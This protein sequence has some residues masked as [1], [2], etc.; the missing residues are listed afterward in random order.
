VWVKKPPLNRCASY[1]HDFSVTS[2]PLFAD[3]HKPLKL[4]FKAIWDVTNL[5]PAVV[6]SIEPGTLVQTDGLRAYSVLKDLGYGHEVIHP[7]KGLDENLLPRINLTVS[8]LKRWLL[9]T[10]QGYVRPKHADD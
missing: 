6:Q 8:L 1:K 4:W 10:H 7:T 9:G 2:G 5:L 3:T